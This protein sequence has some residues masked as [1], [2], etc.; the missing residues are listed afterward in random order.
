LSGL[1]CA[2]LVPF[3]FV[4]PYYPVMSVNDGTPPVSHGRRRADGS[5]YVDVIWH[6]G[7]R[8]QIGHFKTAIEADERIKILLEAWHEGQKALG[9]R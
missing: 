8:Q 9:N 4:L 3:A 1:L 2:N 6:N 7:R 5:W